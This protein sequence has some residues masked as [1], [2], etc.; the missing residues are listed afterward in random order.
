MRDN[1]VRSI[2][3]L[4]DSLDPAAGGPVEFVRVLSR[5]HAAMG[6]RVCAALLTQPRG[7]APQGLEIVSAGGKKEFGG[8]GFRPGFVAWL[9][10][11]ASRHD[12]IFVHGLWQYHGAAAWLAL[13]SRDTPYYVFPH[14]M[15][16]PWFA[17]D[18]RRH[19]KKRL[20]WEAIEKH[21]TRRAR[22]VLFT[23]E[24]E[25]A[26]APL[27]FGAQWPSQELVELGIAEPPADIESQREAFLR[28]FPQLR[29]RQYVLFLG[30]VDR[31][32][33]C[34][35]LVRAFT[36]MKTTDYDLVIAGPC[37]D[38]EYRAELERQG[39]DRVHFTGML[40]GSE[41]WGA[42]RCA[43][44]FALPSHQEN[45]GI[46][47][48]EALACGIPALISTAVDIHRTVT[49]AGAGFAEPDDLPGA[50]R[51]LDRWMQLSPTGC[52]QMKVAARDCFDAHFQIRKTALRILS[53][54]DARPTSPA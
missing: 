17:G 29:G 26:R 24:A 37:V 4:I 8:Y 33:G 46:A 40:E 19:M 52:G 3:H 1:M 6:H 45:F 21:V 34:D 50:R 53:L 16:D 30:R 27:S 2:L 13:S 47:V 10:R 39:C 18:Q 9:R 38:A 23:S 7:P 14:G 31:K 41:K 54:M 44:A 22:A 12:A 49:E 20:Y 32:K 42:F 28:R 51:L 5:E 48:S 25:M 35:L 15:L 43:E 36:E 11:E